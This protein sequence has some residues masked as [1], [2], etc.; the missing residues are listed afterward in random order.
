[1]NYQYVLQIEKI[2]GLEQ[3]ADMADNHLSTHHNS[4]THKLPQKHLRD[5]MYNHWYNPQTPYSDTFNKKHAATVKRKN[6]YNTTVGT[7]GEAD[8]TKAVRMAG[9]TVSLHQKQT[10]ISRFLH[11]RI[12]FTSVT[13][14]EDLV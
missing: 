7:N 6:I 14:N 2:R 10:S 9:Q 5:A 1:M 8:F 11:W 4:S 12:N 13:L 3:L